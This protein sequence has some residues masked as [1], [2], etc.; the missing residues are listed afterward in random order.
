VRARSLLAAA[1]AAG[2]PPRELGGKLVEVSVARGRG[3]VLVNLGGVVPM[4]WPRPG[5]IGW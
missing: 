1:K 2:F 3:K 5:D 4:N